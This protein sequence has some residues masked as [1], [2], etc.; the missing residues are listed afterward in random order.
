MSTDELFAANPKYVTI[1]LFGKVSCGKTTIF[2]LFA[3]NRFLKDGGNLSYDFRGYYAKCWILPQRWGHTM[4]F[5]TDPK[6]DMRWRDLRVKHMRKLFEPTNVLVI[7]TDS[8]RE[9]VQAIKE[10]FRIWPKIKRKLIIFIIANMQ[11]LP[12]RMKTEEIQEFLQMKDVLGLCALEENA[13]EKLTDFF[14][15]ATMR[16]FQMISKKYERMLILDEDEIGFGK[17]IHKKIKSRGK[18][19]SRIDKLSKKIKNNGKERK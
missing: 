16:Y 17:K 9:D 13:K 11:D 10:S 12:D 4:V 6:L 1:D 14:E 5:L 3:G 19:S 18:Y 8:T 7:V 15:K 2:E